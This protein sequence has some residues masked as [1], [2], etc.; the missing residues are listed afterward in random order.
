LK[1]YKWRI[2]M[3]IT[4]VPETTTLTDALDVAIPCD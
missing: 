4:G 3:S 1:H 2:A